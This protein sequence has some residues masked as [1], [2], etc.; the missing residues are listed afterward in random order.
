MGGRLG[1]ALLP[2]G[3]WLRA[4][5]GIQRDV[6]GEH[7][8][9][10]PLRCEGNL[11]HVTLFQG[12]LTDA[13]SPERELRRVTRSLSLPA[14]IHLACAGLVQRPNGW[15]FLAMERS[16]LLEE[17]QRAVLTVLDPYVDRDAIDPAWDTSGYTET[18]RASRARY[19]YRYTGDAYAPHI[20]LGRTDEDIAGELVRTAHER[21]T[22][23]RSWV[24]DRMSFYAIGELGS[25]AETLADTPLNDP[26]PN[27]R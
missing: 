11:P 17:V 20:T 14:E 15:V 16:P 1:V 21:A 12:P 4:A 8:L 27:G 26:P 9:R 3:D 13:L 10:P 6:G 2:R 5:V 25:H 18:E 7:A 19:G 22:V 23:P 24:F